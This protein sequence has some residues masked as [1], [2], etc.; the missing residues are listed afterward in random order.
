MKKICLC[1]LTL[2]LAACS[3]AQDVDGTYERVAQTSFE[4]QHA[5][6][7]ALIVSNNGRNAVMKN[8]W[9]N[10]ALLI[11]DGADGKVVQQNGISLYRFELGRTGALTLVDVD[12]P[13]QKFHFQKGGDK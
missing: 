3:Q 11:T 12:N 5:M 6:S 2:S 8:G 13:A 4:K 7:V 9:G 1:C 10:V